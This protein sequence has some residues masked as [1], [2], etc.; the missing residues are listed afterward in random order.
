[1]CGRY[2]LDASP[3][4]LVEHF[5]LDKPP[6]IARRFNIAPTQLVAVVASRR[7]STQRGLALLK[8]GLVPDWSN[9]PKPGPINAR[10]ETVTWKP[11]FA[12]SFRE[13]RCL[14]LATGLYEWAVAGKKKLP[15]FIRLKGGGP[16]AFAGLW[17]LWEGDGRRLFTTC[18]VTVA[19]NELV[20]PLHDRMPAIL[21]PDEYDKWLD[22]VTPAAELKALLRPYPA[23]L[24]ETWPVGPRVGSA[25]NEGPAL[26]ERID[27]A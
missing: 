25:K 23:D 7:D 15:H 16:M 11:T 10:A 3:E 13:K 12:D 6:A 20:K 14:I 1:M 24:M 18:I 17:S 26:V 21:G 27:A 8:W 22:P 5:N 4:E 9:D 2:V 19:A